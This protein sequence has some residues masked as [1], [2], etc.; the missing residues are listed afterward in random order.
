VNAEVSVVIPNLN[1]AH[2]LE[3][4]LGALMR[5]TVAV[6]VIVVDN[7]STDNSVAL[8][9]DKFPRVQII[10]N[11]KNLG[12]AAPVNQGIRASTT[13]FVATLNNDTVPEANWAAELLDALRRHP[14]CG[15]AASKMLFV[16]P[17]NIINSCGIAIDRVGIAWDRR[18]GE[19]DSSQDEECAVF[20]ASAGAALYRRAMLDQ[21]GLFDEDFFAYMEDVDLAWRA[22]NAGWH[23]IYVPSARVTHWHSATSIEGSPFKSKMLGRNKVWLVAKNYPTPQLWRALPRILFYE[24]AAVGYATLTRGDLNALRG[25]VAGWRAIHKM[26][27]KRPRSF[28]PD[29]NLIEPAQSLIATQQ[30]YAHIGARAKR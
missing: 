22:Q 3:P 12:F 18:G 30:R 15:S 13:S 26:W 29:W 17:P 5:Q 9:R 2:L 24:C 28:S 6:N 21:I 11:D 23:A 25:R 20:G 19:P 4:C 27:R 1:G 7:G 10:C 16:D 14:E 8:M